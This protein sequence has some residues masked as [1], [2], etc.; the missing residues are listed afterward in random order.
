MGEAPTCY[1]HDEASN[2]TPTCYEVSGMAD[3]IVS[4]FPIVTRA[5]AE[6]S[7][8]KR[9]FT[10]LSCIA[11]HVNERYVCNNRCVT[12]DRIRQDERKAKRVKQDPALTAKRKA[13]ALRM[14]REKQ[15]QLR[16]LK[17]MTARQAAEEAG[18]SQYFTGVPCKN[19]HVGNRFT[20][21]GTCMQCAYERARS[22]KEENTAYAAQWRA[23]NPGKVAEVLR[24]HRE[25]NK[26][27]L[28]ERAR[29]A[30]AKDP[31][32]NRARTKRWR[33]R[34]PDGMRAHAM[35]RWALKKGSS[36]SY[37]AED[38]QDL[39]KKQKG[40]CINCRCDVRKEYHVDHIKPLSRG[41]PNIKE[42]LQIL[43]PTCNIK[44]HAKDPIDWAQEN[45]RLL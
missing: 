25:K 9:Y 11:G 22:R 5:E 32:K 44:K 18:E 35:T 19:G 36:G 20:G 40:K 27:V 28:L 6:A 43:C 16:K 12:C 41:G 21:S 14:G 42:N 3:A 26:K 7:G 38:V 17:P 2:Q 34:N 33:E 23:A 29:V 45:G 15:A 1:Q 31:I 13:D 37:T 30:Y 8:M 10:G 39:L 24:R 4:Q